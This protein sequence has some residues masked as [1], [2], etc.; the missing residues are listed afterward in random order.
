MDFDSFLGKARVAPRL[1]YNSGSVSNPGLPSAYVRSSADGTD[2]WW[3]LAGNSLDKTAGTDPSA[4]FAEDAISGTPADAVDMVDFQGALIVVRLTDISRLSTTWNAAW[5]STTLAQAALTSTTEHPLCVTKKTGVLLIGDD[6]K[7][8]M[9]DKN[10]NVSNGRL[11]WGSEYRV[12]WIRSDK[13]GTWIGL[14]NKLSG[15]GIACFWDESSEN[16]NQAYGVKS[17]QSMSCVIKNGVPY[18]VNTAGQ[19]LAFSGSGFEEVA[20]FPVYNQPGKRWS[21]GS[22]G[23]NNVVVHRNGMALVQGM[24]H[25]VA[26]TIINNQGDDSALMEN[27]PSGIWTYDRKSGLRH[28]YSFNQYTDTEIDYGA[29][30]I[31]G[32]G[33]IV[34]TDPENGLF[35]AGARIY[36][37]ATTTT[38][39]SFYRDKNDSVVKRGY[40]VT[41]LFESSG[42]EDVFQDLLLSFKRFRSASDRIV[43]KYRSVKNINFPVIDTAAGTWSDTDTFTTTANLANVSAGDEVEIIRGRGAGACVHISSLSLA[44]GT[45]TVNLSETIPNVSGSMRFIVRNFRECARV[46]SQN[47]ERQEF[48]IDVPG[49]FIQLKVELRSASGSAGAGDSPEL[50]MIRV[51][52]VADEVI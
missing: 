24:I 6:N 25:I 43:V 2:R 31:S 36:T 4:A 17:E 1:V 33:A 5:W 16:Y 21:D 12:S 10:N 32:A 50:E 42:F 14:R 45:Y 26:R 20:V 19:L 46:S 34:E 48:D 37:N 35:L 52:S 39:I 30:S 47:I 22:A 15:E 18:I 44:A 3:Q 11:V 28:K 7:V 41:S 27:F 29:F 23:S 49:T 8:H 13:D 9:V 40:F 38:T 51:R